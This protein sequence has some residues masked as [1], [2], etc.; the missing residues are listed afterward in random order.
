M[1]FQT[2]AIGT[3]R[4]NIKDPDGVMIIQEFVKTVKAKGSGWVDYKFPNPKT[5]KMD[6]KTSYVE[7]MDGW[8]IGC[9]IYK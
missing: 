3:N 7:G 1:G 4:W 6:A 9:G 8:V 5:N 2:A